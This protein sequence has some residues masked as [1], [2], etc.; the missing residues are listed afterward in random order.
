ML[1]IRFIREN[2]ELVR[3]GS[4][5]KNCEI[6]VD[7]IL[8]PDQKRRELISQ[9]ETLKAERNMVTACFSPSMPGDWPG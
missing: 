1:D 5:A 9:V 6:D 7:S 8:G 3:K 2:P 4:L